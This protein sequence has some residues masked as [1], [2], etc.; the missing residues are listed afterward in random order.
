MNAQ[1]VGILLVSLT[2][3]T[4]FAE[5]AV[6]LV[7]RQKLGL[8]GKLTFAELR[9]D[10]DSR[11]FDRNVMVYQ[12]VDQKAVSDFVSP[13]AKQLG[14]VKNEGRDGLEH[15][16]E[17][18]VRFDG[19]PV[20]EGASVHYWTGHLAFFP[21]MRKLR[22][23]HRGDW[24]VPRDKLLQPKIDNPPERTACYAKSLE[25]LES[26][27]ISNSELY[28]RVG[29]PDKPVV[30]F[31]EKTRSWYERSSLTEADITKL[32]SVV[33]EL[34]LIFY[35]RIGALKATGW[36]LG[37]KVRF[38]YAH[39]NRQ[40]QVEYAL[41]EWEPMAEFEVLDKE[42]FED[43]LRSGFAFGSE[44]LRCETLTV[45]LVELLAACMPPD[46][47]QRHATPLFFV[48]ATVGGGPRDRAEVR[49]FIPALRIHRHAYD[50]PVQPGHGTEGHE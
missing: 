36:G 19:Q 32:R 6:E 13:L 22:L 42:E 34:H 30:G 26:L 9:W 1:L 4:L 46:E 48:K 23:L 49:L 18:V 38:K 7:P 50:R 10:N 47:K 45:T 44:A 24:T 16:N 5:P 17:P 12:S 28:P 39:G 15:Q 37:G 11:W 29:E 14:M 25:C 31:G 33:Y 21:R 3:G 27:G 20:P 2:F 8:R 43:A 41:R 40:K 35:Q